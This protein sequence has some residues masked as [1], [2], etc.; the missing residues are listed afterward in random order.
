M[1]LLI[2]ALCDFVE[3]IRRAVDAPP[4][5]SISITG[6]AINQ[7]LAARRCDWRATRHTTRERLAQDRQAQ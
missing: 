1:K 4:A 6:R 2:R 7:E 5:D 3:Q